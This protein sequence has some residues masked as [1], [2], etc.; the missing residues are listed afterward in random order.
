MVVQAPRSGTLATSVTYQL[1]PSQ[2][3]VGALVLHV[4]V[5]VCGEVGGG[6]SY[7]IDG[8]LG[9]SQTVLS[10]VLPASDGCWH[11][12]SDAP[13]DLSVTVKATNGSRVSVTTVAYTVTTDR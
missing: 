2:L 3:P 1:D 11:L 8:P 9:V 13:S 10:S 7:E 12:A 4:E 5:A 6:G